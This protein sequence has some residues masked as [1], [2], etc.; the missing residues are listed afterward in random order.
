MVSTNIQV[1]VNIS[2]G[3]PLNAL[4]TPT[5]RLS[6]LCINDLYL[7]GYT[8]TFQRGKCS[9]FTDST[10]IIASRTGDLYILQSRYALT[11]ETGTIQSV[12]P[13]PNLTITN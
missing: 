3:L 13:P 7:A 2:P 1:L 12:A 9:I 4:Y 6:L 8:T 11:S 5:F 10:N